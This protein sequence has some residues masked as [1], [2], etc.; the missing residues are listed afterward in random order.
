MARA[1]LLV[2]FLFLTAGCLG[3]TKGDPVVEEPDKLVFDE[4][5][6]EKALPFG[7]DHDHKNAAQHNFSTPNFKVLGWNP[8]ISSH[9]GT[10][11]GGYLCGDSADKGS[12]R[13]SV[14]HGLSTDVA[15]IIVDVTDPAKPQVLGELTMPNGGAR[16]VAVTPDGKY[17]VLGTVGPKQAEKGGPPIRMMDADNVATWNSPCNAGP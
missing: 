9:Y 12:R 16:D 10:S 17:V 2:T 14:V 3:A 6:A 1:A 13:I 4:E 7:E 11:A 15:L 8:L 5:W